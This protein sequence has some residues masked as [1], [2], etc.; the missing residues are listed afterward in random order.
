MPPRFNALVLVSSA[1]LAGCRGCSRGGPPPEAGRDFGDTSAAA[2]DALAYLAMAR[3]IIEHRG[4]SAAP[5]PPHAPGRRVFLALWL[6]PAQAGRGP[7]VATAKGATLA[8][9]VATAADAI[10]AKAPDAPV[11][12]P[13]GRLQ[14]DV[15]SLVDGGALEDDGQVELTSVGIEGVLVTRDDGRVGWVLPGEVVQRG[16]FQV[17]PPPKLDRAKIASLLSER[18]GV[19]EGDLASMRWYQFRTDAHVESRGQDRALSVQRG[20]VVRPPEA[21]TEGLLSAVRRGA[22]YLARVTD[23][24]GRYVYMYHPVEDRDDPSYGWLR[25]AGTTYALLEAYGEF[26]TSRYLDTAERAL[27]YL[28]RHLAADARSQGKYV[29]DT[30]DEEQQKVGGAGLVLLALAEHAAVTG[31]RAKLETMRSLAR[32]IISRQYDDGH[33][34]SNEDLG[35]EL[36]KK[37]K[38]EVIYYT[39]EATLALLR[40]YGID[41]Q[42]AYLEAAHKAADWVIEVRDA[43]VSEDNQEHDHWMS[44]ACNDLY[45]ATRGEAYEAHAFKI[46]RAIRSKQH[47]VTGASA[48]DWVGT[49]YGGETTPGATRVEAYDA[50]IALSRF[51]GKPDAWLVDAAKEVAVSML[52]QQF[53]DE[54]DYWLPNPTK[55]AGGVRES[56]FVEDVRIDYVQHAMS[57][58]LH[59]ARILRDPAYGRTGA[60]SQDAPRDPRPLAE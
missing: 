9:S 17:G 19:S 26:G 15:T 48:P 3:A 35:Q 45:R 16:L 20:M 18:A 25:H 10:A 36:G 52:G 14:L 43:Y 49:F 12:P 40:L 1:L 44:Y 58:W 5:E 24:Q 42:P 37:L 27:G 11:L 2:P 57:A 53:S 23:D 60:P 8:D 47:G 30:S 22:E 51:A 31:D 28:E 39:G 38:K 29:L 54:N 4:R 7:L 21:T 46:A 13:G 41:P 59:L 55:A 34:R 56:L 33:F 50:D 32:F 6:A